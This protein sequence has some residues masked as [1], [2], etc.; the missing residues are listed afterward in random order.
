[1]PHLSLLFV[2]SATESVAAGTKMQDENSGV[3]SHF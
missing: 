3:Y 2:F 1:M